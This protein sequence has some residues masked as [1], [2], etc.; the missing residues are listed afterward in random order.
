MSNYVADQYIEIKKRIQDDH[1]RIDESYRVGVEVEACLLDDKAQPV[2]AHPLIKE[3][4][5]KYDVDS[6]YGKCQFEVRTDPISM[7]N[8]SSINSF[9]E[10]FLDFLSSTV[11]KVYKNRNVIPDFLGGN[12]SPDIFKR[13]YITNK[14]RYHALYNEQRKIPDIELEGQKFKARDIATAIQG[15]HLHLQGKNPIYTTSMFNYIL[16]LIPSALLIGSN[17]RLFAGRLFSLYAPRIYLYN[18]SEQQTSGFP[19]LPRYL[20]KLEDYIDYITSGAKPN[21]KDYFGLEKDRHDDL[22][23][24]LNSEYYRVETRI[25]SVQPTPKEMVAMIEFFIGFLYRSIMENKPLRPLSSIR[26]ERMAV[27]RSG[28]EARTHF[29]IS[30]TVRSQLHVA[31]KGLIDLGLGSEFIGI[32]DKRLNNKTSPAIYVSRLWE[33]TYNGNVTQTVSDLIQHVWEKTKSNS[34]LL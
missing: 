3:L 34:P 8:L 20:D 9:F 5:S 6:E 16:N 27:I 1:Q 4:S 25:M 21:A 30:E 22:R 31:K 29:D 15:F 13:K 28:Y 33:R 18:H 12:P 26:E 19:A 11:K 2:N 10:G 17:S 32:L 24:R 7:H 14:E 23:I